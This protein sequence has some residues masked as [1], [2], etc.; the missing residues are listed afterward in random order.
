MLANSSV[1]F[2]LPLHQIL[3]WVARWREMMTV[4]VELRSLNRDESWF[5]RETKST[6]QHDV[7]FVLTI[8]DART[9]P[10]EDKPARSLLMLDPLSASANRDHQCTTIAESRDE[11]CLPVA[12]VSEHWV[13]EGVEVSHDHER[14]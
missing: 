1:G 11:E 13:T 10:H 3:A 12:C 9:R 8:S 6:H 2:D 14:C 5:G 4:C 7:F